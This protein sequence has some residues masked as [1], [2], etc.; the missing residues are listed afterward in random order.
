MLHKGEEH[1]RAL[2]LDA[3]SSSEDMWLHMS[4][5]EHTADLLQYF[6]H[7]DV[8][9]DEDD[10]TVRLLGI[11][12]FNSISATL[13]LLLS[14]YYQNSILQQ[15]DLIETVFLLDYFSGD[16]A[17]ISRWRGADEKTLREEF[18]PVAVRKKLDERDQYTGK[19]RAELYK[20]FSTLAG[21]P[22][23]RGFD[24]LKVSSGDHHCGPFF[25]EKSLL[26]TIS[27]LERAPLRLEGR[28]ARSFPVVAKQAC[29]QN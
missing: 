4:L 17:L 27:D 24:M 1:V 2:S 16:T 9:R 28:L 10:L 29:R 13:K 22:N 11:R 3:I 12:M 25:D 26:A 23:P 18:S 14:G 7:R 6:I 19:K 20:L 8:H 21:H 15:R 5:I